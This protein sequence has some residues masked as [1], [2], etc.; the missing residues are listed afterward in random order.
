L[1]VGHICLDTR[2][3][4]AGS[5]C[6]LVEALDR[7]AVRQS[8]L[9]ADAALARRLRSLPFVSVGSLVHS[10]IMATCLMPGVDIVHAH[11]ERSGQAALLLTL[12]RSVPFLLTSGDPLSGGLDSL[13]LAVRRRA[14][15]IVHPAETSGD[16]L[17]A[18]YRR[19]LEGSSELPKDANGW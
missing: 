12:T 6:A 19:V 4:R 11:D 15:E 8:V 9:V 13:A 3:G 17:L 7:L 1:I 10:P 18:I 2:A 14:R 5:F 16:A